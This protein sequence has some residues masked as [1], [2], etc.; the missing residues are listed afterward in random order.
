[1]ETIDAISYVTVINLLIRPQDLCPRLQDTCTRAWET[2][3]LRRIIRNPFN[4]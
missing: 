2:G 1:M 3:F 4:Y